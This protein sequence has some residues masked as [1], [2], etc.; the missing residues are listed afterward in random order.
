MS[1]SSVL[2]DVK[3]WCAGRR[4]T[5]REKLVAMENKIHSGAKV[6]PEEVLATTSAA[7]V[8]VELMERRLTARAELATID[9]ELAKAEAEIAK[10]PGLQAEEEALTKELNDIVAKMRQRLNQLGMQIVLA[11]SQMI[12]RDN[13]IGRRQEAERVLN[14]FGDPRP[15]HNPFPGAVGLDAEGDAPKSAFWH[16]NQPSKRQAEQRPKT[17]EA[18]YAGLATFEKLHRS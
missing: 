17:V 15:P 10:L 9:K 2:S 8:S 13:Q 7:G 12:T 5:D 3:A 14:D 11:G 1:V 6:S 16:E 4:Q 18:D